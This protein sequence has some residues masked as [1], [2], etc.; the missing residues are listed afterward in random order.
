MR[1]TLYD[2]MPCR[3]L[4]ARLARKVPSMKLDLVQECAIKLVFVFSHSVIVKNRLSISYHFLT[5]CV[6]DG[7]SNVCEIFCPDAMNRYF[8][9]LLFIG[10]QSK[11]FKETF[12]LTS[13]EVS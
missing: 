13:K 11:F 12:L 5:I 2:N 8:N 6:Y 3:G 4:G 1:G 10:L 9:E 7:T